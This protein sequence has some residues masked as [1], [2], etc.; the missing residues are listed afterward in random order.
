MAMNILLRKLDKKIWLDPQIA[1]RLGS[2]QAD[3][4]KNFKTTE[5]KLSVFI[6]AD[7]D[8]DLD[9]ILTA[10]ASTRDSVDIL[11]YAL[12]E[13]S[14]LEKAGIKYDSNVQGATADNDVNRLH[15]DL[16]NLTAKQIFDLADF[17]QNNGELKRITGSQ[18]KK[19]LLVAIRNKTLDN[20][21]INKKLSKELLI[22]VN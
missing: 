14:I 5:N 11:D 20:A 13:A 17:I 7:G 21:K 10:L 3:A 9:R 4:L 12:F 6:V 8:K 18:V 19:M 16:I 2:L 22:E 15:I 1:A